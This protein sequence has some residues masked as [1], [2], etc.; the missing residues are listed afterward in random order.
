MSNNNTGFY[1]YGAF[2]NFLV[3]K[4]C[5]WKKQKKIILDCHNRG[6]WRGDAV[7]GLDRIGSRGLFFRPVSSIFFCKI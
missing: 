7:T 6:I 3:I 4:P 1:Y 2:A 5:K